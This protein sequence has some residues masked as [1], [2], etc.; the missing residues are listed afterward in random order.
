MSIITKSHIGKEDLQIQTNA[1]TAETFDRLVS[2]G[3]TVTMTKFPDI[4]GGTGKLNIGLLQ[5]RALDDNDTIL[6]G[7]CEVL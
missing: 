7:F 2:T 6:H 1:D 4:F 3:G 5:V